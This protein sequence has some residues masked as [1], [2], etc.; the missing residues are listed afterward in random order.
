MPEMRQ[1]I[2]LSGTVILEDGTPPPE[3]V[4]IERVCDGRT[5]PE[6]YT[7]SKGHFSFQLG[8][9]TVFSDASVSGGGAP[10]MPGGFGNSN[11][12]FS[13]RNG[14]MN[15]VGAMGQV[16]L[17][18]CEL[19]AVLAGFISESVQLGRR[20]V[21]D[22]PDVGTIILKRLGNVEGT[23]ISFTTLAAPKNA[24]KAYE[25]A[26]K[27]INRPKPNYEKAEKELDKAVAEYPQYASA[28]NLLGRVR[29]SEHNNEGAKEAFEK[30]IEADAKYLNPYDP[31][32]RMA[33]QEQNWEEASEISM[34][35]LKLNP[36][37]TEVQYFH[38]VAA[39]NG[40]DIEAAEKS[41]KT[42]R[43]ARDGQKF[44]GA[45]HLLGMILAKKGKF[46]PAA[47]EFR[48][49]LTSQPD[50]SAAPAV[51]RQLTEWEALGVI[52]TAGIAAAT[53]QP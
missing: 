26:F 47:T 33:L 36:H 25:N 14:G 7:N 49:F 6:G 2:F 4:T 9:N 10:G 12:P 44:P 3:P 45:Q 48:G 11:D 21:F 34:R 19:R 5:T 52:K 27:E 39:F 53:Q 38:A 13:S 40:G 30:A 29:L 8:N 50:S 31:L 24:K 17:M 18:G 46:E 22:K 20:S 23:S 37:A 15:G 43:E 42:V 51:R 32:V 28:W 41:A 35:L 16:N 1:Q